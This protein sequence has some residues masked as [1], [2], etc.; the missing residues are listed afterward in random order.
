MSFIIFYR[1]AR[2]EAA[3]A[4]AA[5]PS[6]A[7]GRPSSS[8]GGSPSMGAEDGKGIAAWGGKEEQRRRAG[9]TTR[10]A[11]RGRDETSGDE[12]IR[13]IKDTQIRRA[14]RSHHGKIHVF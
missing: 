8:G 6:M 10:R 4:L 9:G 14:I 11:S 13:S 12:K 3:R 1:A 2:A 7:I 5:W